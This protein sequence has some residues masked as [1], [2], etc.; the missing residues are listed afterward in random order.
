MS[1]TETTPNT[2]ARLERD[3]PRATV[4]G[5][6]MPLCRWFRDRDDQWVVL[7]PQAYGQ[8]VQGGVYAPLDCEAS[9]GDRVLVRSKNGR[10]QTVRLGKGR[11]GYGLGGK[12]FEP[13][14]ERAEGQAA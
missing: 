7:V 12:L 5:K 8:R 1:T 3:I 11:G 9:E 13:A 6:Q 2:P 14:N 10:T 4:D